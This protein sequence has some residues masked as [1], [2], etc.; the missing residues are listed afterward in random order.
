[1]AEFSLHQRFALITIPFNT[2]GILTTPSLQRSAALHLRHLEPGERFAN[3]FDPVSQSSAR[4]LG[5]WARRQ[6]L[7]GI[8]RPETGRRVVVYD[9]RS[10]ILT[11]TIRQEWVFE[12]VDDRD[13]DQP[14]IRSCGCASFRYEIEYLLELCGFE[15]EALYGDFQRRP[16]GMGISRCGS[17]GGDKTVSSGQERYNNERNEG[18]IFG[19][20][21]D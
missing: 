21:Y 18:T 1:M 20:C 8:R 17:R 19:D 16:R 13:Y 2:F 15:I 10:T 7:Q 11:Q 14:N 5:R 3:I 6:P 9:A 4:T 12:Q